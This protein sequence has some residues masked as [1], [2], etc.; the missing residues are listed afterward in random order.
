MA[1]DPVCGMD[2]QPEQAAGQSEYGG[3]TYYF[4]CANCKQQFDKEP[5][6]YAASQSAMSGKN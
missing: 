6:R 5:Q 2:G 4:C 3:Q 1:K